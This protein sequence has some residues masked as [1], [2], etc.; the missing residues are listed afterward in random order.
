MGEIKMQSTKRS[1]TDGPI[2][3]RLFLFTLPVMASGLLQVVY[4]MADNIVVGSFSGDNLALA[5]VGSTGTLTVLIVNF[6]MGFSTGASVVIAH[7]YGAG[8]D[9]QLHAALHTAA[10]IAI[11]GGL[12]LGSLAFLL[13][14]PLLALMGTK[15]ELMSRAV[16]YFRIIAVGI[17]ATTVYNLGASVLRATGDSKRPL[18]VLAATGLINVLLNLFFVIVLGM[19]VDGV[20]LA[21]VISQYLSAIT[22][23]VMLLRHREERC[24]LKPRSIG[25]YRQALSRIIR[26]AVPASLQASLFAISNIFIQ[27][28]INQLSVA[29]V[30]GKT[31]SG[32]IDG[33][34]YTAVHSY[35]TTAMTFVAQNFGARKPERVRKTFLYTVIQVIVVGVLLGQLILLFGRDIVGV[36]VD[37][38]DPNREAVIEYSLEVMRLIL[39]VYFM[40]GIMDALSG[41]LRG[42]G[43]SVAPMVIG[44]VGICVLRMAWILFVFPTEPFHNLTGMYLC[45]PITWIFCIT[46]LAIMLWREWKRKKGTMLSQDTSLEKRTDT[47]A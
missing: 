4:N 44:I 28:G 42:L 33:L 3:L 16:L 24:R 15:A 11:C 12:T 45:Y 20:A 2:F 41:M 40:C 37:A 9:N 27:G 1:L 8:D 39:T 30:S 18:Y 21:T 36:Y 47:V 19:T 43:N 6:L 14:N 46:L 34:V 22:V 31:I 26:L 29:E 17:P 7:S 23:V 32:N 13:A 38:A 5:A 10:V 25:V 35:S